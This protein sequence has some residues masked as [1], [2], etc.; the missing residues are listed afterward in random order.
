[1]F[2]GIA[3]ANELFILMIFTVKCLW[4]SSNHEKFKTII[5]VRNLEIQNPESF[6]AI[7][8]WACPTRKHVTAFQDPEITSF[9]H[10]R[11]SGCCYAISSAWFFRLWLCFSR[12]PTKQ[13]TESF[14]RR[15]MAKWIPALRIIQKSVPFIFET[16]SLS[17]QDGKHFQIQFDGVVWRFRRIFDLEVG[18]ESEYGNI[19]DANLTCNNMNNIVE[20]FLRGKTLRIKNFRID[21]VR[22][23]FKAKKTSIFSI[24]K[25]GRALSAY[26]SLIIFG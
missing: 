20:Y 23:D 14:F 21:G 12:Y 11:L 24:M 8:L 9:W 16:V 10:H 25:S 13:P 1:M 7:S 2:S 18:L 19:I 5:F 3:N 6:E 22:K 17:G 26:Q 15:R 4:H